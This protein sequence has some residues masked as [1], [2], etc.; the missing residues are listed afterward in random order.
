[1]KPFTALCL[2]VCLIGGCT[3]LQPVANVPSDLAQHF[4][5]G[6]V[7]KA[8]DRVV[9]TTTTGV[10]HRFTIRSVRDGTIYGD[11]DSVPFGEISS[12]QRR[13]FNGAKTTILVVGILGVV[14][15]FAAAVSSSEHPSTGLGP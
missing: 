6:G 13:E 2:I 5:D 3:T 15:A 8:G 9:I 10:I 1:M 11:H 7:L 12:V 14:A 4:S